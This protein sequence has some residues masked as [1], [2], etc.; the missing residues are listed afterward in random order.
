MDKI[1]IKKSIIRASNKMKKMDFHSKL[2]HLSKMK[3]NNFQ[4]TK[5]KS[6]MIFGTWIN[7]VV[8]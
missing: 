2:L 8:I 5:N 4:D 1:R 6:Q 7:K 3:T